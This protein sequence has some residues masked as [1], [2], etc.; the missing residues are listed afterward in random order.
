MRRR[1]FH[2]S[3]IFVIG[4]IAGCVVSGGHP[5]NIP[6]RPIK[7]ESSVKLRNPLQIGATKRV[8]LIPRVHH[9]FPMVINRLQ[10]L[11][12]LHITRAFI[13]DSDD[14]HIRHDA[15]LWPIPA[16][17]QKAADQY[18]WNPKNPFI[19]GAVIQFER[20][21]GILGPKGVS[22][23]RLHKIVIRF[24]LAD[25]A[26]PDPYPWQW[27]YVT[28]AMGTKQPEYLHLWEHGMGYI[29]HTRVNTGVLGSTP[30]GTWPVYQRLP[31][32][33]MRGVFPIPVSRQAYSALEGQQVPQWAGSILKQ[34]AVGVVNGH[35]V[36]WQPYNDPS[37]KWVSYFD[38]GRGIHYYPRASYGF[39]QSAGC[40]EEPRKAAKIIYG[41]LHYGVP[42]TVSK[43]GMLPA[44]GLQ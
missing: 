16:P 9:A 35:P 13:H 20:I 12:Y 28:K 31:S 39:P 24:I 25:S 2:F 22:E 34:S 21:N 27:V 43:A 33:T 8:T 1:H 10:F 11:G 38:D 40:V 30:D 3:S 17:L 15:F 44:R 6:P 29:W 19:R 37:I 36:R 26:K 23:G 41:L 32:T 7:P 42:V 5:A 18:P 14:A 4:G